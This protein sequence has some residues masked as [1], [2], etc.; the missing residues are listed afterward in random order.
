M[1]ITLAEQGVFL[2]P[3]KLTPEQAEQKAGEHKI[4]VF[5]TLAKYF[6]R[7]KSE[8]IQ[9]NLLELRYQPF[10]HAAGH[11]R[12]RYVR[13]VHY[14]LPVSADVQSVEIAGVTY[15]PAHGKLTL[16]G[17]DTCLTEERREIFLDGLTGEVQDL[18]RYLDFERL[19]A[20]DATA[21][22]EDL[23]LAPPEVRASS[24]VRQ[25]LGDVLHPASADEIL[26][27]EVM[28]D[29]LELYYRPVYAF[30]CAWQAKDKRMT[31]EVDGL[32]GEFKS[33]GKAFGDHLKRV[34]N[35]DVLLDIGT[36]A[37]NLVLPG[38]GAIAMKLT[39]AV[40]VNRA[41]P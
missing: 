2:L 14:S 15:T 23:A 5:G 39:R 9:V 40:V 34:L 10:W 3:A 32:N 27:E 25:V 8:D 26:E 31:V 13:R 20:N 12:F 6:I 38:T 22:P 1:E 19:N 17:V 4:N 41:K 7:P 30:E 33:T 35:R 37:M 18:R 28:L 24:V 29:S 21:L 16:E 36:D 11:K